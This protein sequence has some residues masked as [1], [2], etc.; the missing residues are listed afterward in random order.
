[1]ARSELVGVVF[2]CL[3]SFM[4]LFAVAF[5]FFK[6]SLRRQHY[7]NTHIN[8]YFR[9]LLLANALQA[10]ATV[11]S[12]KWG[13]EDRVDG[14]SMYCAVQGALKQG[15]NVATALWA[16]ILALHLFN[17]LFLRTGATLLSFWCTSFGAWSLTGFVVLIGPVAIQK[18]E[19]GPYFGDSGAWC[20]IT[21]S[22]PLEQIFLE[23][24][25]EYVSAVLCF[26]LYV[27]LILRMRGDLARVDGR[28]RIR[29]LP[30]EE[31]WMVSLRRDLID[32]TMLQATQKMVWYPIVY[33]LL[34]IPISITR[35]SSFAGVKVPLGLI[36]TADIFF[37]LIGFSNVVL[38]NITQRWFPDTTELPSFNTM[39]PPPV[40]ASLF[41]RGGVTP[42]TLQRS[43][44]AEQFNI[45][46]AELVRQASITSIATV[47]TTTGT[48][49]S[50][51]F[52]SFESFEEK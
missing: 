2:L 18:P 34:I 11:M 35:I 33:T 20:W 5:Y 14:S 45:Q 21:S 3:G 44:S 37:N 43:E 46:R 49:V 7:T 51:T 42:F 36:I 32:Y 23:Y 25:F 38:L 6:P 39:R 50:G 8:G 47:G 29:F 10:F 28:W 26:F 19:H 31:A 22:Y 24:F 16:F 12:I 15:G 13:A 40:R 48:T 27:F 17:L 1:M 52:D 30:K 9:Q 4:T 41:I